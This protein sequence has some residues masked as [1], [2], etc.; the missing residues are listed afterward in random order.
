VIWCLTS[1]VRSS[2]ARSPSSD[3]ASGSS[4][5][6][7]SVLPAAVYLIELLRSPVSVCVALRGCS[8]LVS[9]QAL[10]DQSAWCLGNLAADS[11]SARDVLRSNGAVRPLVYKPAKRRGLEHALMLSLTGFLVGLRARSD[12]P[13]R[14]LCSV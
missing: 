7:V 2:V 6:C 13:L 9:Q 1:W 4:E 14:S 11:A 3:I 5:D 8:S 10:Q 12:S